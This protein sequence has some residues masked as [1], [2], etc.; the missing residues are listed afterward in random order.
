VVVAG[1]IVFTGLPLLIYRLR[2]PSWE[3][4][5]DTPASPVVAE[6]AR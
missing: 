5:S 4:Q 1:R 6:A 3:V 2:R